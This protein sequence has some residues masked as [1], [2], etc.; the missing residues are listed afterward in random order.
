MIHKPFKITLISSGNHQRPETPEKIDFFV[1]HMASRAGE[2]STMSSTGSPANKNRVEL[3]RSSDCV[4]TIEP[5]KPTLAEML[6]KNLNQDRKNPNPI[7]DDIFVDVLNEKGQ[8]TYYP[9]LHKG[10]V[11][12]FL[13]KLGIK[14][15]E[16]A[17]AG[18]RPGQMVISFK[19]KMNVLNKFKNIPNIFELK[20]KE[21][22]EDPVSSCEEG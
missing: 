10:H 9:G 14:G 21:K 5:K 2:N 19:T 15:E 8:K 7:W 4:E 18:I 12:P 17:Y 16:I 6:K 11:K 1:T 13:E 22:D 3:H 20:M